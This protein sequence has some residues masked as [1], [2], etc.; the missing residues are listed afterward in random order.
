[1]DIYESIAHEKYDTLAKK[2]NLLFVVKSAD[3]F[4]LIG[5]GFAFWISIDP[6]DGV[7]IWYLSVNN[8]GELKA[9]S[10][11]YINKD[12]FTS[13]D[14]IHNENIDTFD[15]RVKASMEIIARGL[16]NRCHDILSGDRTWLITYPEKGIYIQ[17]LVEFLAPYFKEQGYDIKTE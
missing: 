3:E 2:Y 5:N 16:M 4:C 7:D 1:M 11:M 13:T 6:R 8:V 12:R 9:Y 10:L 17:H 14:R 15:G